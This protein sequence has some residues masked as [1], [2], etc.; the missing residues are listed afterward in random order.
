MKKFSIG[1]NIFFIIFT[2][3]HIFVTMDIK[4]VSNFYHA[5]LDFM[6]EKYYGLAKDVLHLDDPKH[7]PIYI[8]SIFDTDNLPV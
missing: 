2:A 5:R 8:K 1:L 6:T 7:D 4:R 3:T